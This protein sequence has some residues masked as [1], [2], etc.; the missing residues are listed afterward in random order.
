MRDHKFHGSIILAGIKFHF[1]C[2]IVILWVSNIPFDLMFRVA[3]MWGA[4]LIQR[5]DLIEGL[6]RALVLA[7]QNQIGWQDQASLDTIVWPA[8]KYDVVRLIINS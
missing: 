7:G 4:K 2:M 6:M 5:R 3:G 1:I 8:A